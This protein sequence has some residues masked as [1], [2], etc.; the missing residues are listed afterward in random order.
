MKHDLTLPSVFS[1]LEV[2]IRVICIFFLMLQELISNILQL[3][4][5]NFM[6]NRTMKKIIIGRVQAS[7]VKFDLV[8]WSIF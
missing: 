1:I 5:I 3:L 4:F 8:I 2:G 7:N 6:I